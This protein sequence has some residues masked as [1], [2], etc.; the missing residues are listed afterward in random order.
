M[1]GNCITQKSISK[2]PKLMIQL[3]KV[4]YG[5]RKVQKI[6]FKLNPFNKNLSESHS[7]PQS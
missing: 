3:Y 7:C 1:F 6:M 5:S 4:S 2:I